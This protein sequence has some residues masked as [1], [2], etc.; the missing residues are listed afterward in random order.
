MP[1]YSL[2]RAIELAVAAGLTPLEAI[3]TATIVP[4][5]V[6]GMERAVGTI[7]AGKRADLVVLDAD[8]LSNI[9]NIRR[10][11]WV[12]RDGRMYET[13]TLW[14]AAGFGLRRN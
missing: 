14:R 13:R 2:L 9:A 3:Q 10:A 6:M 1:G 7:E 11:V 12:V 4:A 5:R 8:P